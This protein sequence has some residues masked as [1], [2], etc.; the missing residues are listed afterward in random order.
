M[1]EGVF[2]Y[3]IAQAHHQKLVYNVLEA[4]IGSFFWLRMPIDAMHQL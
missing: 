4:S 3:K 2:V 1:A